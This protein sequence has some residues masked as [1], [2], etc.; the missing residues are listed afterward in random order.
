MDNKQTEK[1]NEIKEEQEKRTEKKDDK[2]VSS[3]KST[4]KKF[5]AKKIKL[6][7]VSVL[8]IVIVVLVAIIGILI[9]IN[10]AKKE[11]EI[12]TKSTLEKIINVS[13]LSTFEAVY[14]GVAKSMNEE[15]PEK[16][17]YHVSYEAKVK[18]GIEFDKVDIK[19]D[20]EKKTIKVKI[21]KVKITEVVVDIASLDYL[22]QNNKANDETVSEEAYKL[23]KEDVEKE[24]ATNDAI[25]ELAEENAKSVIE[26]LI[27]PFVSQLDSEYVLEIK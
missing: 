14:N 27:K 26:A 18:A 25:Y 23:C 13:D 10:S 20:N 24:S 5:I 21:P 19:I 6:K 17:D 9:E 4:K 1:D 15:K 12:I 8:I 2:E 7:L 11:K 22:F 3:K 16:V